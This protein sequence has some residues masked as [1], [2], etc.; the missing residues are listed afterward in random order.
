[1][2]RLDFS[3]VDQDYREPTVLPGR[4]PSETIPDRHENATSAPDVN[5][6]NR[7]YFLR[8]AREVEGRCSCC[9][10]KLEPT[11]SNC[12]VCHSVNSRIPETSYG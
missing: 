12:I 3:Y 7:P 11:Q 10:T 5:G 6:L 8:K 1:M 2:P 9:G 4:R